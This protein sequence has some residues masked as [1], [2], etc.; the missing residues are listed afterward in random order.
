MILAIVRRDTGG[1]IEAVSERVGV[2]HG[3]ALT[4]LS[5]D[6]ITTLAQAAGVEIRPDPLG[7]SL[8]VEDLIRLSDQEKTLVGPRDSPTPRC[9]PSATPVRL[10]HGRSPGRLT[11]GV[12]TM[13]RAKAPET[14]ARRSL[15]RFT[16][17]SRRQPSDLFGDAAPMAS[18][19]GPLK[20]TAGRSGFRGETDPRVS[21]AA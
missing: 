9:A 21:A 14:G 2:G 8:L 12:T 19:S 20:R 10:R 16:V 1:Y 4:R 13:S 6:E 11:G 3:A 5:V 7:G 18:S 15:A 17:A